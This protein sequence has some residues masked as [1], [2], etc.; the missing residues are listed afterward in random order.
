MNTYIKDNE[1]IDLAKKLNNKLF[2]I[3]S[4]FYVWKYL[5]S[6]INTTVVGANVAE[7]NVKL[8]N[9][10]KGFFIPVET[11]LQSNL[12]MEMHKLFE[13]N[14]GSECIQNLITRLTKRSKDYQKE[15]KELKNNFDEEIKLI[16]KARDNLFAHKNIKENKLILPS[17]S[18]TDDLLNQISQFLSKISGECFGESWFIWDEGLMEATKDTKLLIENLI[19]GE[20]ARLVSHRG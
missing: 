9:M 19:K 16:D 15:Y 8:L 17:I 13:V 2:E 1:A 6:L 4:I 5:V 12:I 11:S 3:R 20:A 10:Y 14:R 18:R 7:N